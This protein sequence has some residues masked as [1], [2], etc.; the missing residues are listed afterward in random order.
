MNIQTLEP[1]YK[2]VNKKIDNNPRTKLSTLYKSLRS[3]NSLSLFGDW[4]LISEI[5]FQAARK[6]I[7]FTCEQ[8]KNAFRLTEDPLLLSQRIDSQLVQFLTN[9]D[10]LRSYLTSGNIKKDKLA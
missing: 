1:V 9:K 6:G 8:V 2:F 4:P 3:K 7:L 10:N 5:V